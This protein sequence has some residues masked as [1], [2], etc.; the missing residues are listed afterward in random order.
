MLVCHTLWKDSFF[1]FFGGGG[2]ELD[3]P[4]K[5]EIMQCHCS[6]T[7]RVTSW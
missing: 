1:F 2:G 7:I 5:W 6:F 4:D 3:E